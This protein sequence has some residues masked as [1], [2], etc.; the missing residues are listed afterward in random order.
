MVNKTLFWSFYVSFCAFCA[1]LRLTRTVFRWL[2][3]KAVSMALW[4]KAITCDKAGF[5]SRFCQEHQAG[6]NIISVNPVILSIF[7]SCLRAFV[8]KNPRNLRN[9]WLIMYLHACKVLYVCRETSTSIESSLQISPLFMQNEP[10][11]RKS[12]MNISNVIT[13]DYEKRTL[14]GHGK[15]E[16]KTNPIKANLPE[17]KIDVKSVFTKDYEEN[18]GFGLRK[19]EPNSNPIFCRRFIIGRWLQ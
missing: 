9:P 12:Q 6:K 1:S 5:K 15:N 17:G 7:S 19:N 16:P 4:M 11:F 14:S 18:C 2:L 10:N 3:K 13:T 8:V